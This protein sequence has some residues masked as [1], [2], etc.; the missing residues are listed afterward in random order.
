MSGDSVRG[1]A[2]TCVRAP[3]LIECLISYSSAEVCD[4]ASSRSELRTTIPET[5]QHDLDDI[6]RGVAI[7]HERRCKSH[8][9]GNVPACE[10]I[11]RMCVIVTDTADKILIV[12]DGRRRSPAWRQAIGWKSIVTSVRWTGGEPCFE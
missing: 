8:Q 5:R 1:R 9:R 4:N 2:V 6:L 7:T 11:E 10:R 12:I 3:P